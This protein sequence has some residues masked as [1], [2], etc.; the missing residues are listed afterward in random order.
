MFPVLSKIVFNVCSGLDF[1]H[2]FVGR[3]CVFRR[4]NSSMI[5]GVGGEFHIAET[6]TNESEGISFQYPGMC[7]W[8]LL[9]PGALAAEADLEMPIVVL[10]ADVEK[11]VNEEGVAVYDSLMSIEKFDATQ[12]PGCGYITTTFRGIENTGKVYYMGGNEFMWES[13]GYGSSIWFFE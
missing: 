7:E 1:I 11:I 13:E 8:S 12:D 9:D 4:D 2:Q 6:Y 3:R 5:R 10:A